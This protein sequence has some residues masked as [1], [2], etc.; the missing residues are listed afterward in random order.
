LLKIENLHAEI[1]GRAVLKGLSLTVNA[2]AFHA[3]M[4]SNGTGNPT[5]DRTERRR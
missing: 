4:G 1:H 5:P 3:I 2:G